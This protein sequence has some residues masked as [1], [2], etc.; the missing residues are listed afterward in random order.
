MAHY[1]ALKLQE[2]SGVFLDLSVLKFGNCR[3][4]DFLPPSSYWNRPETGMAIRLSDL[5]S[6]NIKLVEREE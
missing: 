6:L 3:S 1:S 4:Q 5:E 2:G